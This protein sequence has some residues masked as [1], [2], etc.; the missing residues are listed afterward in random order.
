M[1]EVRFITDEELCSE[2]RK[3]AAQ[4]YRDRKAGAFPPA[5]KFGN[6]NATIDTEY[7]V[8]KE[9]VMAKRDYPKLAAKLTRWLKEEKAA[10]RNPW[11]KEKLT[12]WVNVHK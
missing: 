11:A 1:T 8:F 5:V 12:A 4:M 9:V 3:S 10:G 6:R 7:E 2:H